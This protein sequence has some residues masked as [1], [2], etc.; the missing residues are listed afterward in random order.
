MISYKIIEEHL[1]SMNI[2]SELN[3]GTVVE[4]ILPYR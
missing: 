4:I 2:S 1:G 3:K